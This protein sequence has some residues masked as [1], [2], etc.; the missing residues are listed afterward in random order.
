MTAL[1]ALGLVAGAWAQEEVPAH[2]VAARDR[3]DWRIAGDEAVRTLSEYLQVDTINPPGNEDRGVEYLGKQLD[4]L[5]IPWERIELEP[6]RA[7]LIA[8][9]GG[10]GTEPPLCLMHHIDVVPAET[11]QWPEATGPLSGAVSDGFVWGRGAL[12]M[13][14]M[15]A[16]QLRV[17]GWLKRLQV[18]LRRDVVM[19]AV[20]DEE[21]D[22]RGIRQLV[23][24]EIWQRIGC[25]QLINEGGLGVRDALF[26]GQAVHAISVAEKGVLWVRM[27]ASGRAGHGSV[28]VPEE[29]APDRLRR[30]MEAL[31]HHK[32][33]YRVDDSIYELLER[34]GKQ[35]GGLTGFV[36]RSKLLVRTLAWNRLR[37][38]PTTNATL[39]DTV[40]LTGMA[41]A[42]S[43]NVVPST[44]SAVYDCRLLPGTTPEQ[45]LARLQKRVAGIEGIT[46]E[47]LHSSVANESPMED[48]LYEAIARYAVEGRTDAVAGPLLSPGF[49]D[50]I[51][52]RPLGVAAY[53]YV[54]FEV[55]SEVAATMHGHG[56]RVPVDQ[57]SEG[58]RR[59]FS[60]VVDQAGVP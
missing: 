9:V 30:A 2:V 7:S 14:G 26:E 3:V 57:V 60:I 5:G 34:V 29:E 18:P 1:L 12:D 17:L 55:D 33:Q 27:S 28:P 23:T 54:P 32:P 24:P 20:A 49:T 10:Q 47:V 8:R 50:S 39:H 15:G 40:H 44:V 36:L 19:L 31:A 43:P 13:K 51:F 45:H 11:E 52:L 38:N 48:S 6:G 22:N 42:S 16:L 35:K 53:G 46:F 4:E 25:S 56:E 37:A 21:V 59:L 58:L 41:G